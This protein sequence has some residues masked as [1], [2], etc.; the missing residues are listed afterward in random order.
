[1]A[2]ELLRVLRGLHDLDWRADPRLSGL[3]PAAPSPDTPPVLARV[4][5]ILAK[6]ESQ[7]GRERIPPVLVETASWLRENAPGGDGDWVLVHGDYRVG[8][9]IWRADR[10]VGVLDWEG[11][12]I[13]DR[14]E[15]LGYACHPIMRARA[16]E[17][18]AMLVPFDEL[19]RLYERELGR[20]LDLPR[21]HYYVIYALYFHLHT[22]V[23]GIVAAV[24]G[25]DLRVGLGY[26]KLQLVARELIRQITA[27]EEGRHV[28]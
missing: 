7:V 13:G 1:M 4:A 25:A 15:D 10:I 11:A 28:L 18:M 23:S 21:L 12:G 8:N 16:P 22:F 5:A 24:N 2:G 3:L 20:T 19:S 27:F 6:L 17:L 14:L 26:G 9:F